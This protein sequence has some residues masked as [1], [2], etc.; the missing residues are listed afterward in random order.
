MNLKQELANGMFKGNLS[1][2][3]FLKNKESIF[4]AT[5]LPIL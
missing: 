4:L 2:V 1:A 3:P 5:L